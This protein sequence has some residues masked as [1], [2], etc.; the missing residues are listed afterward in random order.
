MSAP[1]RRRG[2]FGGS[3]AFG[4]AL[5]G[6]AVGHARGRGRLRA[7]SRRRVHRRDVAAPSGG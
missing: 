6:F 2:R 7:A 1:G 5:A 3:P 4:R